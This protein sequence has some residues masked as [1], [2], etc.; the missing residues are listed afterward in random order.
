MDKMPE[1]KRFH[2]ACQ[3]H[4][5]E[6]YPFAYAEEMP[7]GEYVRYADVAAH[8]AQLEAR[9]KGLEQDYAELQRYRDFHLRVSNMLLGIEL[10]NEKLSAA[11]D[12]G[13]DQEVRRG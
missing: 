2:M 5:T 9:V 12:G 11:P 6:G 8:I 10:E 4:E 7:D 1:L 13:P 3:Y